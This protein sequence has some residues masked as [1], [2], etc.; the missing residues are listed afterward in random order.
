MLAQGPATRER[1]P[2]SFG[3][4]EGGPRENG[5]RRTRPGGKRETRASWAIGEGEIE[6]RERGLADAA[7]KA[8]CGRLVV[9]P[10]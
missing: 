7:E 3:A 6:G 4:K 9:Y 8:P 5:T 10:S 2:L 1:K